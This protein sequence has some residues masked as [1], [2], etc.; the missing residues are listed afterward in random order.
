MSQRPDQSASDAAQQQQSSSF[1]PPAASAARTHLWFEETTVVPQAFRTLLVEYSHILPEE[2]EE[3]V[4]RVRNRA[5][6][7][8]PYPCLGQFR[9][10]ELNLSQR[11]GDLYARLLSILTATDKNSGTPL[12]LD[13]GACLGQDIRKLIYDGAPPAT[14]AG[15]ELSGTFIELGYELFRDSYSSQADILAPLG[16]EASPLA[17]FQARLEVVQL[18]MI[19]HLFSWEEQVTAFKNAISLLK[20]KNGV[21]II[22]QATGN[23]DGVETRTL[24]PRGGDRTTWKHNVQS[25][26]RLVKDVESRTGTRWE[27]KAELDEGLSVNDGKRSWDDPRTRRLLFEIVRV[28]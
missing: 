17:Q 1:A 15:A 4:I 26:Q 7:V 19:L 8:H 25:F 18:G 2:V 12:F 5:W 6:A 9:F 11:P 22:G 28:E 3:H 13:V 20:D 10:L 16:G 21:L 14:V 23:V 24:A 27:V